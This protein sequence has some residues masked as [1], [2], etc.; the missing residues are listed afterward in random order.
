MIQLAVP[1]Q[2]SCQKCVV[3]LDTR[4]GERKG[5]IRL[6]HGSMLGAAMKVCLNEIKAA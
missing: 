2:N 6:T 3:Q 4:A 5:F 1:K